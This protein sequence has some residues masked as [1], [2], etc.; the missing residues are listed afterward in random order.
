MDLSDALDCLDSIPIYQE[1]ANQLLGSLRTYFEF[2]SDKEYLAN[3]PDGYCNPPYDVDSELDI[4]QARIDSGAY[5]S[6]IDF[7]VDISYVISQAFDGH[8]SWSGD[9]LSGVFSFRL[10]PTFAGLVSVSADGIEDPQIYFTTDLITADEDGNLIPRQGYTPSPVSTLNGVSISTAVQTI[11]L[12]ENIQDPDARYNAMFFELGRINDLTGDVSVFVRPPRDVSAY[13]FVFANGSTR[14]IP[15][16]ASVV[17]DFTNVTDGESAYA[18]FALFSDFY[19]QEVDSSSGAAS[20]TLSASSV[21]ATSATSATVLSSSAASA[22]A[23]S[24]PNIPGFPFPVIKDDSNL[25][26]GYYLNDTGFEDVAVLQITGFEPSGTPPDDYMSAAQEALTYFL[27]SAKNDSKTKLV[28]DVQGNGGGSIDLA[29]DIFVQLF[30]NVVPDQSGN[31]RR[32]DGMDIIIETASSEVVD[33]ATD[34]LDAF[35]LSPFDY[36]YDV[37]PDNV[38]IDSVDQLLNGITYD[39]G[40]FTTFFQTNFTD[41]NI[42]AQTGFNITQTDP[43][44]VPVFAPEDVIVLTDGYCASSCTVFSEHLKN[45]VGVQFVVAGGRPIHGPVQAVGGIKGSQIFDFSVIDQ[46][47]QLWENATEEARDSASSEWDY[48]NEYAMVRTSVAVQAGDPSAGASSAAGG[49]NG[50]NAFRIGDT[51]NTP[52]QY[53][54]DASDCRIWYTPE[55]MYDP[56]FL[57]NRVAEV[58]FTNRTGLAYD[59][60]YC[61]PGSTGNPTSISGGWKTG[62]LGP[63]GQGLIE[64]ASPIFDNAPWVGAFSDSN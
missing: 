33:L 12:F 19:E 45:Q 30:P 42:G 1:D 20:T 13:D 53:V 8:W 52:S 4:I 5:S 9:I 6:E 46:M 38:N 27:S 59:S 58:A 18:S 11:A 7:Q 40:N 36:Q 15:I 55:M 14:T 26:V 23:T 60:P 43:S 29:T 22:T 17:G 41:P 54:Y 35:A 21:S 63:Q 51:S 37:T 32:S 44:A 47:Y 3:P 48:F 25:V 56:T 57:W 50:R 24:L 31:I 28:I 16:V 34:D 2:E 61:T 49:V 64:R 62:T 10:A 39:G